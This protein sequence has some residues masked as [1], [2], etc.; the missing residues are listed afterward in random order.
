MAACPVLWKLYPELEFRMRF[1]EYCKWRM[2]GG[3]FK[4]EYYIP[5]G[6]DRTRDKIVEGLSYEQIL[7]KIPNLVPAE[8]F[9]PNSYKGHESGNKHEYLFFSSKDGFDWCV[10]VGSPNEIRLIKG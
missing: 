7:K 3:N 8:T 4:E 10:V 6:E 5:L 1:P 9:S 2:Q